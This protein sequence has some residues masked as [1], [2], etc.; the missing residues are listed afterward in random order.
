LKKKTC[1]YRERDESK[2][3]AFQAQLK[4]KSAGTVVYVD[5]AGID[6]RFGLSLR[7]LPDWA[8]LLCPQIWEAYARE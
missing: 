7:V 5:E 6:N 4:T 2:R 8:T 1:G 3:Q